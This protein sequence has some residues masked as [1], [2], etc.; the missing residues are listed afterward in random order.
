MWIW[1]YPN[2]SKHDWH[3]SHKSLDCGTRRHVSWEFPRCKL[4]AEEQHHPL[5]AF[6]LPEPNLRAPAEAT[7]VGI[8]R[9]YFLESRHPVICFD[10]FLNMPWFIGVYWFVFVGYTKLHATCCWL[11][12][13]FVEATVGHLSS[14]ACRSGI[15]SSGLKLMHHAMQQQSK[16]YIRRRK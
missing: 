10:P 7:P 1:G 6:Q 5:D 3:R 2:I 4:R 12:T 15:R 14:K 16:N 13:V 8:E 11:Y 9:R